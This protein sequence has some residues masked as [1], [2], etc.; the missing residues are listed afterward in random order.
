MYTSNKDPALIAGYFHEALCE[1]GGCPKLVRVDAGTENGTVKNIQ[2]DVMGDGRN[3][4]NKI[5]IEGTSILNQSIE[6][7][8][9]HLRKQC[10]EFWI[11]LFHGLKEVGNFNGDFLDTN[12]L[13]FSCMALIQVC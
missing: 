12:I 1:M 6:A 8:W 2:E 11:C 5:W 4:I 3:G 7:F 13:Q 9:C 10:L